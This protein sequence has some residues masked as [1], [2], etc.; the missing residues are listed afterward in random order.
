MTASEFNEANAP[1]QGD[2][3]QFLLATQKES[4]RK[5]PKPPPLAQAQSIGVCHQV[6]L[7]MEHL[8]NH[9]F[10]HRDLAARNCL[11]TSRLD[12]KV[13]CPAL[14]RD[15]YANEYAIHRNRSVPIRWTP[16][17]ALFED[18]WSTK[19][20]VYSFAVLAWEVFSQGALPQ[21]DKDDAAV[22]K[23]L[24][25]AELRWSAPE[26]VPV[27]FVE[28]LNR[29]WQRSP[30]DRPAFGE[31]ALRIGEIFVDSNV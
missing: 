14:S 1:F 24:R 20:D 28:L 16:A 3:K 8:A 13:S 2:L 9:R 17:E 21:G 27:A 10:T 4:Q 15:S 25:G 5:G 18:E 30:R 29:C 7:A 11:V 22:L 6:A 23:M 19:S 12:V 31:V 26:N